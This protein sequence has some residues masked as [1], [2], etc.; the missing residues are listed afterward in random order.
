MTPDLESPVSMITDA[1]S[2]RTRFREVRGR[3]G[4]PFWALH[5]PSERVPS[6]LAVCQSVI[7]PLLAAPLDQS[8]EDVRWN[9]AGEVLVDGE[10]LLADETTV[11][12]YVDDAVA[13]LSV[14]T[15][16]DTLEPRVSRFRAALGGTPAETR[17]PENLVAA[18]G[19]FE[20]L[21]FVAREAGMR[22]TL[23]ELHEAMERIDCANHG[24]MQRTMR[25]HDA[26][27]GAL[28]RIV[29]AH[30]PLQDAFG[31]DPIRTAFALH[32]PIRAALRRALK[33][34]APPL[35]APS[36]QLLL[37][38]LTE[39]SDYYDASDRGM[40]TDEMWESGKTQI[41]E[42][43]ATPD[44]DAL[45]LL[46]TVAKAA[47]PAELGTMNWTARHRLELYLGQA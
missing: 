12:F 14:R 17:Y 4:I 6:F 34:S 5:Y 9:S 36:L 33:Q 42:A 31:D 38:G 13:Y 37:R 1:A 25:E 44:P 26:I 39:L 10:Y 23:V 3:K 40:E 22:L 35:H 21:A 28:V 11:R 47:T 45:A 24:A 18:P 7:E 15:A 19:T 16:N 32:V 46:R 43:Y 20:P 29:S 8:D 41:A 27:A 2:A 30:P